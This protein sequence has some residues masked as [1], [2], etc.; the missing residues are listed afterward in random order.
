MVEDGG[1]AVDVWRR[2]G[3]MGCGWVEAG[4]LRD[5]WMGGWVGEVGGGEVI[6]EEGN[7]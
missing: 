4:W 3:K 2:G 5:G 1:V 7:G 6:W